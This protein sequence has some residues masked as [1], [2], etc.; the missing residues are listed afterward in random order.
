ML[1]GTMLGLRPCG[2]N[3]LVYPA[4]PSGYGRIELLDVPGRWGHS[5][6]YG[7]DRVRGRPRLR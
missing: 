7:R 4:L 2:D 5:D 1:L 6:S 3:L